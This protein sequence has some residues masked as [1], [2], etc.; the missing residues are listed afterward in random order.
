MQLSN[1]SLTDSSNYLADPIVQ[2]PMTSSLSYTPSSTYTQ[3]FSN[4]SNN[5]SPQYSRSFDRNSR[6]TNN[7]NR[8][9]PPRNSY[10]PLM[11]SSQ[12]QSRSN[13]NSQPPQ[14]RY[15]NNS[16][17]TNTRQNVSSSNTNR[18]TNAPPRQP[19]VNTIDLPHSSE[20]TVHEQEIFSS[21]LCSRCNQHGHDA[22]A[23]PNF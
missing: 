12:T 1:V 9:S 18:V 3:S 19:T 21:I 15:V 5:Y 13:I 6:F 20:D 4:P 16:N 17:Q 23:C 7:Q 22:T 2:T 14:Q 8:Y 11:S 10:V